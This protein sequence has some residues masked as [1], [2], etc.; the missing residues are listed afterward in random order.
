[1]A[2]R[3]PSITPASPMARRPVL[4]GHGPTGVV[5]PP[6]SSTTSHPGFA[7]FKGKWYITYHTADAKGGDHFR[8]SV[9]IDELHWDDSVSPARMRM[10]QPT[11]RPVMDLPPQRNIAPAARASA[12]TSRCRCNIG[13]ARSM[14]GS[15]ARPAARHVGTWTG[16]IPP[17]MGAIW[18]GCAGADQWCADRLLS[19]PARR[20]E[21]GGGTSTRLASGVLEQG[22]MAEHCRTLSGGGRGL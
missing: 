17:A 16:T 14:T 9:A 4:W 22:R 10:V 7:E 21:R 1:M 5:L 12:S 18:L 8:R 2:A 6:V 19:R 11:P 13:C 15:C 3:P 20:G